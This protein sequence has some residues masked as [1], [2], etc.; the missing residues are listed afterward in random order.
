MIEDEE[1]EET[2]EAEELTEDPVVEPE[3]KSS[4]RKSSLKSTKPPTKAASRGQFLVAGS[5]AAASN[6]VQALEQVKDG[7]LLQAR[8]QDASGKLVGKCLLEST[9]VQDLGGHAVVEG[10]LLAR[11]GTVPKQVKQLKKDADA[12]VHLCRFSKC[13]APPT[14]PDKCWVHLSAWRPLELDQITSDWMTTPACQ[15][16]C[17]R[18][19]GGKETKPRLIVA[20]AEAK[21]GAKAVSTATP[22][23]TT[24]NVQPRH[25]GKGCAQG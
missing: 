16:W 9:A 21:P 25:E 5:E 6:F 17:K 12:L 23:A 3:Q 18:R 15:A 14:L 20:E 4:K 24:R 8:F 7:A 22:S 11:T 2:G 19:R 1:V 13:S 10:R